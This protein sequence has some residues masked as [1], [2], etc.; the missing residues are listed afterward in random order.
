[1][2]HHIQCLRRISTVC[3]GTSPSTVHLAGNH[4]DLRFRKMHLKLKVL[5]T[6][7]L[8]PV[9]PQPEALHL[10][11]LPSWHAHSCYCEYGK[12]RICLHCKLSRWGL[13][14]HSIGL[15]PSLLHGWRIG[16]RSGPS[17]SLLLRQGVLQYCPNRLFQGTHCPCSTWVLGKHWYRSNRYPFLSRCLV[18][19]HPLLCELRQA[20]K[21][22]LMGGTS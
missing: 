19:A 21:Q 7:S 4:L 5:R 17:Q 16:V 15:L 18:Q 8:V 10:Q 2:R 11:R 22:S 3:R 1:M 20:S 9:Y 13:A 6:C 12:S 14:L